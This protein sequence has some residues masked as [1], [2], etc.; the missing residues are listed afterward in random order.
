MKNIRGKNDVEAALQR[1]DRLTLDE[2]LATTAKTLEVVCKLVPHEKVEM[3]EGDEAA[4]F[5]L[6]VLGMFQA[7]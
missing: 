2:V 3:V 1:L 6:D 4:A 7:G 5:I